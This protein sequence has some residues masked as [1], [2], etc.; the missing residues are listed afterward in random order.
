MWH[1]SSSLS[2]IPDRFVHCVSHYV[3][4]VSSQRWITLT[5]VRALSLHMSLR[6][7]KMLQIDGLISK[8]L[9]IN[10]LLHFC[11]ICPYWIKERP[12]VCWFWDLSLDQ[13]AWLRHEN[14]ELDGPALCPF[15]IG[16]THIN[17]FSQSLQALSQTSRENDTW[18]WNTESVFHCVITTRLC[19]CVD[20]YHH[21]LF[22]LMEVHPSCCC[23]QQQKTKRSNWT[24]YYP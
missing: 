13:S 7:M 11:L 9:S 24:K 22:Q 1:G 18:G 16:H 10:F 12:S 15:L 4:S 20:H 8:T 14:P 3:F 23:S 19:V 2:L 6:L 21:V 17:C 5:T